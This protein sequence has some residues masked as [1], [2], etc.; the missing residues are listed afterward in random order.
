M[1]ILWGKEG[2]AMSGV[3][4]LQT[5]GFCIRSYPAHT[6]KQLFNQAALSGKAV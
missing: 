5:A 6:G 4:D 3:S 2:L 1:E